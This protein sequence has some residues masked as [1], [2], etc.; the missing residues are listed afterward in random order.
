ML[1][2]VN[3]FG[4]R[5]A[6]NGTD[7]IRLLQH[8]DDERCERERDEPVTRGSSWCALEHARIE[9]DQRGHERQEVMRPGSA[10]RREDE[11]CKETSGQRPATSTDE[12]LLIP[13][14]AP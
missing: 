10:L 9:K 1:Q 14:R 8:P 5:C 12:T 7:P 6:C 11:R 3:G 13:S 2:L 4:L